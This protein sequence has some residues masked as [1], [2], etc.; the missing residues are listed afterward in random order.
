LEI[1]KA[2]VGYETFYEVSNLGNVR[3]TRGCYVLKLA[4]AGRGYK[5]VTLCKYSNKKT[6]F[7]HRLVLLAFVGDLSKSPH[8][9]QPR[10]RKY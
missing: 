3:S 2:V 5:F 4:D 9:P 10:L 1:W 7:V 8:L 6:W